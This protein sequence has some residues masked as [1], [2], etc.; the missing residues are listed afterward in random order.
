MATAGKTDSI[1]GT[2]NAGAEAAILGI[3]VDE[4]G[5]YDLIKRKAEAAEARGKSADEASASPVSAKSA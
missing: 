3:S 1:T 4:I 2:T 5:I